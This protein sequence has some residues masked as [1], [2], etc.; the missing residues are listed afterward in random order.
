M[1]T[2][3]RTV[4]SDGLMVENLSKTTRNNDIDLNLN[5]LE[6]KWVIRYDP[7]SKDYCE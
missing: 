6:I 3:M 2:A 1:A 5:T 7:S 4:I